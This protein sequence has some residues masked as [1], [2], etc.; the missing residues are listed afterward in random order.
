MIY[1]I[2]ISRFATAFIFLYSFITKLRDFAAFE[3]AIQNFQLL[4]PTLHRAVAFTFMLGEALIVLVSGLGG[5]WLYLSFGLAITL[6]LLFIYALNSVL[7]RKIQTNCNCFGTSEQKVSPY[8][9][10]R[11]VGIIL[12]ALTGLLA[13]FFD[14]SVPSV[15][16]LALC[17]LISLVL[18]LLLLNLRELMELLDS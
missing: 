10:W 16:D 15:L 18:S 9:I 1:L 7:K 14:S 17:I 6:L 8:D 4:P 2:Q 11:N 5:N 12:V 13:L 3:R